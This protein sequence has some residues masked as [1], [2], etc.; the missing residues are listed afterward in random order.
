MRI[1]TAKTVG[2]IPAGIQAILYAAS[3]DGDD[4]VNGVPCRQITTLTFGSQRSFEVDFVGAE[5]FVCLKREGI[6]PSVFC[7]SI[8]DGRADFLLNIEYSL[9]SERMDVISFSEA[10]K[11]DNKFASLSGGKKTLIIICSVIIL[12]LIIYGGAKLNGYLRSISKI[13]KEFDDSTISITLTSAFEKK[14]VGRLDAHAFY[15]SENCIALVSREYF[16]TYPYLADL[17]PLEYCELIKNVNGNTTSDII[18]KDGLTYFVFDM[19]DYGIIR[20][21][22]LYVFKADDAFWF[23]QFGSPLEHYEYWSECFD[24]WARS[25]EIK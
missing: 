10:K 5:V 13:P 18:E 8:P 16:S 15:E 17:S 12:A 19:Y 6:E 2:F 20:R 3:P 9:S 14:S 11:R 22:H 7:Y 1:I 4:I 25:L 24:G 23:V 21:F